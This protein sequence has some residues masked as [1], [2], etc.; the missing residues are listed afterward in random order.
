VKGPNWTEFEEGERDALLRVRTFIALH[1]TGEV[2]DYC[3]Q[4]LHDIRM[5]AMHREKG[6]PSEQDLTRIAVT[7]VGE[8]SAIDPADLAG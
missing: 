2:D 4:R 7:G 5:D 8:K 6:A 3:M 1:G